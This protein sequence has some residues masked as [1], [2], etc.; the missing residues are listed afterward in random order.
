MS[1]HQ[2]ATSGPDEALLDA[3]CA[4][5]REA[6]VPSEM[7]TARLQRSVRQALV[8]ER[9]TARP[10]ILRP[11]ALAASLAIAVFS[12]TALRPAGPAHGSAR[13]GQAAKSVSVAVPVRTASGAAAF[14]L[15][16]GRT[17][18]V[19]KADSPRAVSGDV[20]VAREL[21]VDRGTPQ[22]PGTVV[23]YRFD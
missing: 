3:L 10:A 8:H 11:L 16:A 17:V 13:A 14:R 20:E 22:A 6:G 23:F 12:L 7:E 21:Y 15:P 18:R 1:E 5:A 2:N 19:V 9:E 4:R